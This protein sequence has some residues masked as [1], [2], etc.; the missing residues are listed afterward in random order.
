MERI[1]KYPLKTDF[2]QN[3]KMPKVSKILSIQIQNNKPV[4]W[5][6]VDDNVDKETIVIKL[7]TTGGDATSAFREEYLGTVKMHN[8]L[9]FHYFKEQ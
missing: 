9:V 2:S 7:Y 1:F 4:L 6:L 5:A 3:I 8:G